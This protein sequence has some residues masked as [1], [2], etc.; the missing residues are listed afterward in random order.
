MRGLITIGNL[1][2]KQVQVFVFQLLC[3]V[4]RCLSRFVRAKLSSDEI[5]GWL[6]EKPGRKYTAILKKYDELVSVDLENDITEQL[7]FKDFF[8]LINERELHKEI[9]YAGPE[10]VE[11]RS[12]NNLRNAVAHPASSLLNGRRGVADL[13]EKLR[14]VHELVFK[15]RNFLA[16]SNAIRGL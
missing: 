9:E 10:W 1:N 5:R 6:E 7:Y 2:C 12:I 11:L 8:T 15:L 3:D 4:E 16:D 14:K 13:S